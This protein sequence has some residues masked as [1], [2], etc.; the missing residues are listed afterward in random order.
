M[1]LKCTKSSR[2]YSIIIK[3]FCTLKGTTFNIKL[4]VFNILLEISQDCPLIGLKHL[5]CQGT[6]GII[7]PLLSQRNMK[8]VK[9][10]QELEKI[11]TINLKKKIVMPQRYRSAEKKSKLRHIYWTMNS[12]FEL[13]NYLK[14]KFRD[15]HPQTHT[16]THTHTH[17]HTCIHTL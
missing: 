5:I 16:N 13:K 14:V 8:A 11:W 12:K 3:I 2:T 9:L 15:T 1:R 10:C 7:P 6:G 4:E 17:A